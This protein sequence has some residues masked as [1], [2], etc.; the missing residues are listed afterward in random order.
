MNAG[1]DFDTY[2]MVKINA[3][4]VLRAE[5]RS[6]Q[7]R[8]ELI[9]L[10]TACDPYEPAEAR[11]QLT[12]HILAAL[13]D[14][15]N[16]LSV[17]TK[18]TLVTRDLDL[19]LELSRVTFCRVN[20]SLA[21][22]D[23]G[24]W[25]QTEPGA[26]RPSKRLEAMARLAKAGVST[27]VLLAPIIPGLTDSPQGLE[28]TVRAAVEH[29]AQFLASNVLHLRPGSREWF[30]PFLREAYPHLGPLYSRLY[31]GPYAPEEYT[32]GILDLIERLRQRYGLA[33]RPQAPE[34]RLGGLQLALGL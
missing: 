32:Q 31:R 1:P 22:I 26:P 20:F 9:A 18:G 19:L 29:G 25:R 17:T 13:R 28:S 16:P 14:F 24:V 4:D 10:G 5:L 12:R 2:I 30:M 8:R 34:M 21:T 3:P 23:D 15:R 6:P 11:Y 27:G 7:W 33:E